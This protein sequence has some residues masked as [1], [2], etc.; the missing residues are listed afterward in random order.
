MEQFIF[1]IQ[2]DFYN[3]FITEEEMMRSV[4]EAKQRK[5]CKDNHKDVAPSSILTQEERE[6]IV[7]DNV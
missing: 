2:Q 5:W 7:A 3:G 4:I 6:F 1:A